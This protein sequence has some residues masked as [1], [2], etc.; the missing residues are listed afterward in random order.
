MNKCPSFYLQI[1]DFTIYINFGEAEY[2]IVMFKIYRDIQS[3]FKGFI[4]PPSKRAPD[5]SILIR[6]KQQELRIKRA[7]TTCIEMF[8]IHM[9]SKTIYM[10]NT[11]SVFHFS[12]TIREVT[13]YLLNKTKSGFYFHC[14]AIHYLD[15]AHIF[16]GTNGAGKS[17]IA[18]LLGSKCPILSDDAG[19]IRNINNQYCYFQSPLIEKNK[20]IKKTSKRYKIGSIN[21]LKKSANFKLSRIDDKTKIVNLIASQLITNAI[22]GFD[23]RHFQIVDWLF[24]FLN[25][26][27]HFNTLYFAKN[28]RELYN[29]ISSLKT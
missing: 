27:H 20:K 14:S 16:T 24:N 26:L 29:N 11:I 5:F 15:H 4:V 13:A 2:S 23:H 1:A 10:P 22:L 9:P 8:R 6:E 21:F 12:S 19:I 3:F 7:N 28:K 17:T 18:S 25:R